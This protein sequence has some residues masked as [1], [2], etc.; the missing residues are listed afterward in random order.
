MGERET[1]K[2]EW[3]GVKKAAE[4]ERT[5]GEARGFFPG[6]SH[7]LFGLR[8]IIIAVALLV[9]SVSFSLSLLRIL[10]SL[11]FLRCIATRTV[12]SFALKDCEKPVVHTRGWRG[13]K[14]CQR[15]RKKVEGE[16]ETLWIEK[17]RGYRPSVEER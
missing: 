11:S 6:G 17:V 15:N 10:P 2:R 7:W 9:V 1:W 3:E 12:F 14:A 4:Q 13:W 8:I 16:D 5:H